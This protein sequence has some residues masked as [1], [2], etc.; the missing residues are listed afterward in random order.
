MYHNLFTHLSVNWHLACFHVLAIFSI[1]AMNIWV[2]V[3]FSIMVSSGDMPCSGIPGSYD[4]FNPSFFVLRNLHIVLHSGCINLHPHQQ[5]KRLRSSPHP[6]HYLLF[7]D[8]LIVVI[9]TSVRW[10]LIVVLICICLMIS[11]VEHFFMC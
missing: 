6:L 3:S 8:I 10:Y 4:S 5:S 11:D 2:H 1:A 9:L 7:V